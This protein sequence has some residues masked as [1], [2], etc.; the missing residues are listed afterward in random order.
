[1]LEVNQNPIHAGRTSE[2]RDPL[3]SSEN[4]PKNQKGAKVAHGG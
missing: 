4:D 2:K 3:S 1:V